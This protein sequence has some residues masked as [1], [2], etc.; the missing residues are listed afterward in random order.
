MRKIFVIILLLPLALNAQIFKLGE[1][2]GAFVALGVGPRLP[3]GEFSVSQNLGMG[4]NASLSYTDNSFLPLFFY[5]K[6]GYQH[7]PGSQKF[8]AR[9]NY[10]SFSSNVFLFEAGARFYFRPLIEN[11]AILMPFV[12]GGG[13]LA[14][15]E[16]FHQFKPSVSQADFTETNTKTGFH[17]GVG[18]SVFLVEGL[19]QYHFLYNNQF[20]SLDLKIRIPIFIKV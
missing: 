19:L 5:G 17:I 18:L 8:Y 3:L 1:A 7:Y 14:I 11:V 2:R 16:K 15:F 20:L 9:T 13:S 4:V 6:I 10:S 12:E